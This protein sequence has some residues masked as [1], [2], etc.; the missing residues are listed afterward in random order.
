MKKQFKVMP[1]E[2]YGVVV[3]EN[4]PNDKA[5]CLVIENNIGRVCTFLKGIKWSMP[6]YRIIGSI[7]KRLDGV[8]L[9]ESV[10]NVE[11]L[12]YSYLYDADEKPH[13]II[14]KNHP[15]YET[16]RAYKNGYKANTN[17][18]SEEDMADFGQHMIRQF[19]LFINHDDN[20]AKRMLPEY[21]QSLQKQPIP[22]EVELETEPACTFARGLPVR[23][24]CI[25]Q[26]YNGDDCNNML[27]KITDTKT[28]TIYI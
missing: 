14:N 13:V 1:I 6:I 23:C 7:G 5:F 25:Q 8:S 15:Q 2:G 21:L 17:K 28:N 19:A 12:A 27:V 22:T 20:F 11:Q 3:D 18:Y 4:E 9:I 10:D 24:L 26:K 16:Y